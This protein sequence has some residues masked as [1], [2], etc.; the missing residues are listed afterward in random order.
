MVQACHLLRAVGDA[1]RLPE[2][3]V[4]AHG[5]GG[6]QL[7]FLRLRILFARAHSGVPDYVSHAENDSRL[8]FG[9]IGFRWGFRSFSARRV[10]GLLSMSE[11]GCTDDRSPLHWVA[12][13]SR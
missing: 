1:A 7:R 10:A 9:W 8:G 3:D 2:I 4:D 5:A 11:D 6:P 12:G 13:A